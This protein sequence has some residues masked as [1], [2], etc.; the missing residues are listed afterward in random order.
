MVSFRF[1]SVYICLYLFEGQS[2]AS[3]SEEIEK[4]IEIELKV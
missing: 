1:Q 3:P 2:G 4:R